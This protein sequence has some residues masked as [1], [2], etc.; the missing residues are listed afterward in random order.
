LIVCN[1]GCLCVTGVCSSRWLNGNPANSDYLWQVGKPDSIQIS[2]GF[3][4][5]ALR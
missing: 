3:V 5:S 4:S 2:C 1:V